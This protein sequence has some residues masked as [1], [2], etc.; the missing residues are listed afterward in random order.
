MSNF[1]RLIR[2]VLLI[3]LCCVSALEASREGS[4]L[5]AGAARQAA[6]GDTATAL[7]VIERFLAQPGRDDAKAIA[8]YLKGVLEAAKGMTDSAELSLRRL[9]V[10][11]PESD[12]IGAAL[13]QLGLLSYRLGRDSVAVRCLESVS[14]DF[15][16]SA[17]TPPAL[18]TLAR[19]A[20]RSR[21]DH[22][23]LQAYLQYLAGPI[24]EAYLVSALKRCAGLLYE[25]GRVEEA[26][27]L[28]QSTKTA[29]NKDLFELDL[30]TQLLAIGCLTGLGRAD[31]SLRLAEEL[32][33]RSGD[34]L[35][36]L[37]KLLFLLGHAHLALGHLD[38][39]DSAFTSLA[40]SDRLSAEGIE[41]DSLFHLLIDIKL[42]SGKYE[43][44]SNYAIEGIRLADNADRGLEI[45]RMME[46]IGIK[47]GNLIPATKGLELFFNRFSSG[48]QRNEA[49]LIQAQVSAY[50]GQLDR[51]LKLLGDLTEAGIDSV[52]KARIRLVRGNLYLNLGDTL[53]TEA[54]LLDYLDSPGDLLQNKD[55]ILWVYGRIKRNQEKVREEAAILDRLIGNYPASRFWE[56]ASER[57]EEI[58][59][60]ELADPARAANELLEILEQQS[61]Q[62]PPLRLADLVANEL[63]DYER[64]LAIL[65][66]SPPQEPEG[67][68]KL[69]TYRYLAGLKLE[70][71]GS[72]TARERISQ[73]WR[74]IRYLLAHSEKFPDREKAVALFLKIY[75]FLFNSLSKTDIREADNTLRSELAGLGPGTV[76]STALSWLAERYMSQARV[77]SS[78]AAFSLADSARTMW[79]QAIVSGGDMNVTGKA[80]LSLA[81]SLEDAVFAGAQD[82]AANLYGLLLDRFPNSRWSSL[83][84]LR[85]GIIHLRQDRYSLAYRTIEDWTHR[86]RYAANDP[87]VAAALAEASF[88]TG[89]YER[90]LHL[91]QIIDRSVLD[92]RRQRIFSCYS[93]RALTRLGKFSAASKL[94]L[95]F[96]KS[97][98]DEVSQS[99]AAAI[100]VEL[101]SAAGS[102][103]MSDLYLARL[104]VS[105]EAYPIAKIMSL[106]GQL[107]RGEDTD[108][109]RR[110]FER[111][112]R[113]PWNSFLRVD[114]AFEAYRGIMACY[115][116]EK[117]RDKV[118]ETRNEFRKT[119][120][121]RRAALAELILDEIDYLTSLGNLESAATLYDDLSLLFRDVYPEDHTLWVGYRLAVARGEAAK[122]GEA[123]ETLAGRF[124]YSPYGMRAKIM[125]ARLYLG[126][127]RIDQA[128]A[129]LDKL[130]AE[131]VTPFAEAGLRAAVLGARGKWNEALEQRRLQW[132]LARITESTA[133]ALL[134]WAEAAMKVGRPKIAM[135]LLTSLWSPDSELTAQAR[136]MLG[137][138]YQTEGKLEQALKTME[139]VSNLFSGRSEIALRALYQT[140]LIQ[141]AS[142]DREGAV[143]TYKTLEIRAGE[144]SDWAHSARNRLREL[145]AQNPAAEKVK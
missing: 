38:L 137:L 68:L 6:R 13:T 7:L 19:A 45:L 41:V 99:S 96:Q 121:E 53:R 54:E 22:K 88:L 70:R 92:T 15:P 12:R 30:P 119:Y 116:A 37:P 105:S 56:R 114:T 47:T 113:S 58:N 24:D 132:S 36:N 67:R 29:A 84:G 71:K 74:E 86:H 65:Q 48:P 42:K 14:A 34:K 55:S 101:Y 124:S 23:A 103:Q 32:R 5:M 57:L 85:L 27:A 26:Y 8:L 122:A 79:S 69:I 112:K 66:Q 28:L 95:E 17:F 123:L 136:F 145:T 125:L 82:S 129:L 73:A 106:Q 9:I 3:G 98:T 118:T 139:V 21:L 31:S 138:Q 133:E 20:E 75:K 134:G 91:L 135:E 100:A 87:E 59:L 111:F 77:D 117:R 78:L 144:R 128:Q 107:A 120:P 104:S 142:G 40:S 11:Y 108:K 16:D 1:F 90:A 81:S 102:P 25:A 46:R 50:M 35:M 97:Y 62:I 141:E 130:S 64:A 18:L 131:V 126:A 4:R 109:L 63:G 49:L 83:A 44:F 10:E 72:V 89:R 60:F 33:R 51:A 39:A 2:A 110:E 93:L 61:G 127:G 115:M 140:G 94:L 52:L 76:R 143:I 43:D 80:I